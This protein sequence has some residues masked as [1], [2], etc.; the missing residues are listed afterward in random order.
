MHR[1]VLLAAA[2]TMAI[3]IASRADELA[4]LKAALVSAT[5]SIQ[6]LQKRV[7][8]LEAEKAKSAEAAAKPAAQPKPAPAPAAAQVVVKATP[9]PPLPIP[10]AAPVIAP[11]EKPEKPITIPLGQ[12]GGRLELSGAVQL[13]A[14]YDAKKTDPNWEGTL[15]PSKIPVVCPGDPGCGKN[16]VTN[17]NVRQTNL[18]LKGFLPTDMGEVKTDFAFDLWGGADAGEVRMRLTKAWASF[19]PWLFGYDDSLFMDIDVFPNT[20]DFWGPSG[21]MFLRDPQIRWTPYNQEGVKVALALE[22]PGAGIDEGHIVE[23]DPSL[24][25]G[26]MPKSHYPD[27]TAQVRADGTWGHVQLAGVARWVGFDTPGAINAAPYGNLFGWG[28]N[29]TAAIKTV[30]EDAIKGQVAYGAPI[31]AYSNDCCS[32]IAPAGNGHATTLPLFNWLLYY[33]HWWNK[34]WSSSIGFS[35]NHQTNSAGQLGNAQHIGNYASANLLFYPF[36]NVT[37]G[38]E[39]LWGERT[40]KDGQK[41]QDQRVQFSAKVKF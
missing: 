8:A 30:G 23:I 19:G 7:D 21:M 32:D 5:K 4:D 37:L 14:I 28:V 36:Q 22:V 34:Q 15:R 25:G 3:P 26:V 38:V 13:D 6:A 18:D 12:T 33:D 9:A 31:A 39:G 1:I 2:L 16:G 41:G 35:Q 10:A 29:L 11:N 24:A 20:I 17:F 40:N 27:L